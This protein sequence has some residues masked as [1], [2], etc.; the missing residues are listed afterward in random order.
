MT[1]AALMKRMCIRR[2]IIQADTIGM[3]LKDKSRRTL[4]FMNSTPCACTRMHTSMNT[5]RFL[6]AVAEGEEACCKE[7]SAPCLASHAHKH[8]QHVSIHSRTCNV[9]VFAESRVIEPI[10]LEWISM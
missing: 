7:L 5:G 9:C 3:D 10:V 2:S 1:F 4:S 6:D 8:H